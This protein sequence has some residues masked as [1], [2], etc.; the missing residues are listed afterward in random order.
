MY[1]RACRKFKQNALLWKEYLHFLCKT[2]SLHKLNRVLSTVVQL[3]PTVVDFWLISVYTELDMKGNM[4]TSRN[5]MLQAIR[6]NPDSALFYVEYFR[7]EVCFLSKIKRRKQVLK[8]G[9]Q[10][11]FLQ[12]EDEEA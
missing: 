4:F 6:N 11:E 12:G 1:D 3:H 7:F 9:D 2:K 5:L 8:S 10:L